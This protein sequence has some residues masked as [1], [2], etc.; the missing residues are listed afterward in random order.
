[1]PGDRSRSGA[2]QPGAVRELTAS[3]EMRSIDSY[4]GTGYHLLAILRNPSTSSSTT[5]PPTRRRRA[6]VAAIDDMARRSELHLQP[7]EAHEL[8]HLRSLAT[9]SEKLSA[10]NGTLADASSSAA[11][12]CSRARRRSSS[13]LEGAVENEVLVQNLLQNRDLLDRVYGPGRRSASSSGCAAA[14]TFAEATGVERAAAMRAEACGN[15]DGLSG[16]AEPRGPAA[17]D[18]DRRVAAAR[19]GE[20]ERKAEASPG[21]ARRPPAPRLGGALGDQAGRG[22]PCALSR[23]SL[24]H[25]QV[26]E[27]RSPRGPGPP[28]AMLPHVAGRGGWIVPGNGQYPRDGGARPR[29]PGQPLGKTSRA[30]Q[31][32]SSW[33]T[34]PCARPHRGRPDGRA[35]G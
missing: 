10:E 27:P 26:A 13:D 17:S 7:E 1:M 2:H 5:R 30:T 14:G 15:V 28:P 16:T 18:Q 35:P 21:S 19:Q 3:I 24:P 33:V 6:A 4:L 9:L 12:T 22:T 11:G 8:E 20:G 32:G 34:K 31:Y 23:G 25:P 29:R